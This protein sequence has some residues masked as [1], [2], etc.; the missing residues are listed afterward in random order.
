MEKQSTFQSYL[1]RTDPP[2]GFLLN[3][4]LQSGDDIL[5][6]GN[7]NF[8]SN[9][10]FNNDNGGAYFGSVKK[11]DE[12]D[13]GLYSAYI[14]GGYIESKK[15]SR[16]GKPSKLKNEPFKIKYTY[17]NYSQFSQMGGADAI[18]SPIHGD[19]IEEELKIGIEIQW[20]ISNKNN[21]LEFIFTHD[22]LSQLNTEYSE[23]DIW[24]RVP[25][26]AYSRKN[27]LSNILP[28][29]GETISF[30]MTKTQKVIG[31]SVQSIQNRPARPS[32]GII[33]ISDLY[34]IEKD[35][36]SDPSKYLNSIKSK[37]RRTGTWNFDAVF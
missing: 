20:P 10:L 17:P 11:D 9:Y 23:M 27:G 25:R 26:S 19:N 8:E 6:G 4:K 12:I 1:N 30:M 34:V 18:I 2:H 16:K 22:D 24:Y 5:Q 7:D 36:S 14:P 37:K 31:A 13:E 35:G 29:Q 28:Q 21:I 33:T 15:S 3:Q 32:T